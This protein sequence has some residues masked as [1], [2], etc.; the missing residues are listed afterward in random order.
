[1]IFE[2]QAGTRFGTDRGVFMSTEW[3]RHD[4]FITKCMSM[5]NK[6]SLEGFRSL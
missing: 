5:M 2:S 6:L 3:I 1:M 4:Y